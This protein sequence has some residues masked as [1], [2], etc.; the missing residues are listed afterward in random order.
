[1]ASSYRVERTTAYR[2]IKS[3]QIT[4]GFRTTDG[5]LVFNPYTIEVG[6]SATEDDRQKLNSINTMTI[7]SKSLYEYLNSLSGAIVLESTDSEGLERYR[8]IDGD[9]NV[10]VA[11]WATPLYLAQIL[12]RIID[13][14]VSALD[15]VTLQYVDINKVI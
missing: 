8:A 5:G 4:I 14:W 12:F 7:Q 15:G 6:F 2:A 13:K 1:M 11:E 10:M 9:M 3:D